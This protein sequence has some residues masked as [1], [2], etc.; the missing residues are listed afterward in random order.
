[1]IY[2][3]RRAVFVHIPRTAG[4]SIKAAV[5]NVCARNNI[6]FVVS[7]VPSWIKE[8]DRVEIHQRAST[9]KG[10]IREWSDIYR[11]AI[12]RPIQERI[13]S[14]CKWVEHLRR[15]GFNKDPNTSS[16]IKEFIERE[17]YREWIAE[18]WKHY[19]TQFFTE[20]VYGEDLGVEIYPF[21]E[22]HDRWGEICRKCQIPKC[23]LPRLNTPSGV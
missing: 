1:M 20:G 8:F 23:E 5:S 2:L 14:V 13:E 6:P 22:L 12:H 17:N 21:E 3:P 4:H 11:F 19:T 10:Y 16:E 7:T 9:L 15:I 18:N